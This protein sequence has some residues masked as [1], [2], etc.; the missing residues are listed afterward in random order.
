MILRLML[1]AWTAAFDFDG[2]LLVPVETPII[3]FEPAWFAPDGGWCEPGRFYRGGPCAPGWRGQ[4]PGTPSA[5]D[6][7]RDPHR[8]D[9]RWDPRPQPQ[10]RPRLPDSAFPRWWDWEHPVRVALETARVAEDV[11]AAGYARRGGGD[12]EDL[13][14]RSLYQTWQTAAW[15]RDELAKKFRADPW[16]TQEAYDDLVKVYLAAVQNLRFARLPS[17]ARVEF[18]SLRAALES[19][20]RYYEFRPSPPQH[21]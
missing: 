9:P 3:R 1:C 5:P 11:Y 4:P 17:Q 16:L 12:D 18:E 19:L 10:P 13:A 7:Y 15:Y 20:G 2:S 21:P 8:R 6:P 14:L